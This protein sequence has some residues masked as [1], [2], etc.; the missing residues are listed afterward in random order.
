MALGEGAVWRAWTHKRT[1][2][3]PMPQ[4]NLGDTPSVQPVNHHNLIQSFPIQGMSLVDP[5]LAAVRSD[6]TN[7]MRL[8]PGA[9]ERAAVTSAGPGVRL[10]HCHVVS[11]AD[12]GMIGLL[13]VQGT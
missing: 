11:H 1:A 6:S 8:L 4:A 12:A 10:V 3:G 7:V 5:E 9:A 13:V 2:A